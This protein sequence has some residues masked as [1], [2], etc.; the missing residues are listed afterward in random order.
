M[1]L[2]AI[3]FNNKE[4][5]FPFRMATRAIPIFSTPCVNYVI[6]FKNYITD[7]P[8]FSFIFVR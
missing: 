1:A 3:L 5:S 6:Y 7:F 4:F 2:V 8:L